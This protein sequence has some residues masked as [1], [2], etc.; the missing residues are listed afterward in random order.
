MTDTNKIAQPATVRVPI[1]RE[2]YDVLADAA[3]AGETVEDVLRW[4]LEQALSAGFHVAGADVE[5]DA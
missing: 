3:Q 1:D 4:V 2:V 5:D